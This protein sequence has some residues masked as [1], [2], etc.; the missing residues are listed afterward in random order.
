MTE[1][2]VAL[3]IVGVV[4]VLVVA[5]VSYDKFRLRQLVRR[6][7]QL[8]GGAADWDEPSLSGT[9][10]LDINPP[11][12]DLNQKALSIDDEDTEPRLSLRDI[13]AELDEIE[14]TANRSLDLNEVAAANPREETPDDIV[15]FVAILPGDEAVTRDAVLGMYRQHEYLLEKPHCIFGLRHPQGVWRNLEHEPESARFTDIQLSVQLAD[16]NGPLE[17]AELNRLAQLGLRVADSLGRPLMFSLTFEEALDRA[18]ALDKFCRK[19]DVLAIVNVVANRRE[20]FP[21]SDIARTARESGLQFGAM[22]IYHRK[23]QQSHGCRHLFSMANMYKPGE[24]DPGALEDLQTGGLTLFMNIPCA[25]D[26]SAVFREMIDCCRHLANALDGSLTDRE[27][28]A[29]DDR[30][31]DGIRKQI[32][33]I[34]SEMTQFGV[35]P[36]SEAAVRLF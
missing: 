20:G 10:E 17:E 7:A 23:N 31:I 5:L 22:N 1:L 19:Y 25:W 34:A 3:A 29:L 36:G 21:G 13:D 2:R 35:T 9:A 33:R 28:N 12:P 30:Q 11:P 4:V 24:F 32:D 14:R 15:D 18:Q 27:N 8:N 6:R 26:P 16:R